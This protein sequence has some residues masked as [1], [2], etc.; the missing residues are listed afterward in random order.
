MLEETIAVL[1]AAPIV[2]ATGSAAELPA[3][4]VL[5]GRKEEALA[6]L[7]RGVDAGS[8]ISWQYMFD[9]YWALEPLRDD[10]AFHSL[11]MELAAD[12]EKQLENIRRMHASG[13]LP[14]VPGMELL[15]APAHRGPPPT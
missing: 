9:Y 10:P 13:E 3:A 2:G 5:A 14:E 8:R 15:G 11:R 6:A 7:R 1:E 4:Y 12:M